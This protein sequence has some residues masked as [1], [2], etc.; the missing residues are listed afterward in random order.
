MLEPL[1]SPAAQACWSRHVLPPPMTLRGYSVSS[2]DSSVSVGLWFLCLKSGDPR[3]SCRY[4]EV[5]AVFPVL[6]T[7]GLDLCCGVLEI[8][9]HPLQS[10][11]K[12]VSWLDRSTLGCSSDFTSLPPMHRAYSALLLQFVLFCVCYPCPF[13]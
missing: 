7:V 6:A 8:L 3:L 1:G 9:R 13:R 4:W 10:S 11:L 12:G 2:D 5:L